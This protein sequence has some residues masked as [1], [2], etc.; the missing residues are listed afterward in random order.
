MN[1][2]IVSDK[3][4]NTAVVLVTRFVKHPKY[5]KYQKQSKKYKAHNEGNAHKVGEKVVIEET[6]PISKNKHFKI[7]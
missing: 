6:K 4:A 5:H 7:I 2:V 3:M 1:G